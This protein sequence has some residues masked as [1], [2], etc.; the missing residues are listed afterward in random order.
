MVA[1]VTSQLRPTSAAGARL[2]IP[3]HNDGGGLAAAAHSSGLPDVG[4]NQ[5]GAEAEG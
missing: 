5:G 4:G 2:P 3:P 1:A